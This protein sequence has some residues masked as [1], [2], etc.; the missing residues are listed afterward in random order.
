[1]VSWNVC[2]MYVCASTWV[3]ECVRA[4]VCACGCVC[5]RA[6]VRARASVY[7]RASKR[8]VSLSAYA[9]A[10]VYVTCMSERM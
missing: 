10:C 6:C 8:R 5:V 2:H 1:M 3:G 4:C 9:R 7:M